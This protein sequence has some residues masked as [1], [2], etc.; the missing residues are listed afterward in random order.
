MESRIT[1]ERALRL[2]EERKQRRREEGGE[3]QRKLRKQQ[4]DEA[5]RRR[6]AEVGR[7][8]HTI[9][10]HLR[11]MALEA[12]RPPAVEPPPLEPPPVEPI[13]EVEEPVFEVGE[14]RLFATDIQI[15]L[16][17]DILAGRAQ[18]ITRNIWLGQLQAREFGIELEEGQFARVEPGV[19]GTPQI[20]LVRPE[21]GLFY[22]PVP[23]QQE[24]VAAPAAVPAPQLDPLL[25]RIYPDVEGLTT[26]E[27]KQIITA[28]PDAFLDDLIKRGRSGDTESLLRELGQSEEEI[29]EIFGEVLPGISDEELL[30]NNYRRTG[31]NFD[32][33]SW[34]YAGR[35]LRPEDE[36]AFGLAPEFFAIGTPGETGWKA[37]WN[38]LRA[39]LSEFAF[40]SRSY[41]LT[42]L[43]EVLF[44]DFKPD[45]S[46][47][48]ELLA[49]H[50]AAQ[51]AQRDEFRK[52]S[53][54]NREKYEEWVA[55]HPELKPPPEWEGEILTLL[56]KDPTLILDP[57]FIGFIAADSA[58]FMA[59]FWAAT[60]TVGV[61]TKNPIAGMAAGV[62]VTT[63]AQSQDLYEDLLQSGATEQQAA[64]LAVPM[65]LL[66]SSVE[67]VGGLAVLRAVGALP[68]MRPFYQLLRRN[69][70][71]ELGKSI[72]KEMAKRGLTS[73]TEIQL[74]EI[75]EEIIQGSIQ[76][77]LVKTFDESRE[78][79]G[80]ITETVL[81]TFIATLPLGILGGGVNVAQTHR[82]MTAEQRQQVQER[83]ATLEEAG[84]TE[85][86]AEMVAFT[87]FAETPEGQVVVD[88]VM[89]QPPEVAPE[90]TPA[91][92]PTTNWK[93]ALKEADETMVELE[94]GQVRPDLTPNT[95]EHQDFIDSE[96]TRIATKYGVPETTLRKQ[97]LWE[98]SPPGV[99]VR[100]PLTEAEIDEL[101][102]G[103]TTRPPATP[104]EAVTLITEP[105][106]GVGEVTPPDMG[107][108]FDAT[109]RALNNIPEGG[110]LDLSDF[111]ELATPFGITRKGNSF[112]FIDADG[113][114]LTT[115]DNAEDAARFAEQLG[116]FT[117]QDIDPTEATR[118]AAY[119]KGE[120]TLPVE[121]PVVEA[122]PPQAVSTVGDEG[123]IIEEGGTPVSPDEAIPSTVVD[124]NPILQDI[125]AR[126]KVRP[127]RKVLTRIGQWRELYKP[128]Q[129]AEVVFNE[130]L[131]AKKKLVREL[132]KLAGKDKSRWSL[133]FREVNEKGSQVGLTF[134][135]KRAV[136]RIKQWADNWADRKNLP[137]DKRIKDYI[138]HLFEEEIT[139]EFTEEAG[140][141]PIAASIISE[142]TIRKITD[143]FLKQRLGAVGFIEDPFAAM[144]AYDT[145]SLRALHYGPIL[146]RLD[147]I[148][149]DPS[150][151]ESVATWLKDYSRRMTG[152]P[153]SFDKAMNVT[154]QEFAEKVKGLPGI[155]ESL[156]K[157]LTVGNPSGRAVYN[158]TSALYTMWLGFKATSAIRNLSQ[159]TLI[160][161]EVGI[162][163]FSKGIG[164][165]FTTEGKAVLA[166]S[167]VL[168][169]RKFAFVEGLDSSFQSR[170][171]KKFAD[172]ALYLFRLADKQNVSDAFLAGYSEGKALLPDA[173]EQVWIDR[174]DE[175]AADT[176][177]LYTKLNSPAWTQD[178]RGRVF[179]MLTSWTTNWMELMTKWIG[180]K[181]SQV[182][183]EQERLTGEKPSQ[184]N[185]STSYKAIGLYMLIVA[186]AYYV[187]E[188]TRIKAF[189]YTGLTSI[190]YL[191]GV[192]GGEFPA[193]Q[194]PGAV[195]AVVAGFLTGDDRRMKQ[196][197]NQL[198]PINMVGILRQLDNVSSGAKDW[199][200][201]L[202]YLEGKDIEITR[203][204]DRW[205]KGWKP[206]EDLSDPLIRA[207]KYPT[208]NKNTAQ[209]RWR[210]ENPLLEVQMFVVGQF[211]TL[212]SEEARQE[213]LRL[214][215]KHKLD[216]ELIDGYEKV[217]GIDTSTELAPFRNRIG[218]LEKLVIGE[219][220]EYY[221]MGRFAEEV[222]KLVNSQGKGKVMR[223]GEPLAVELLNAEDLWK[224]Y[225]DYTED[226]ARKLY[227]QL[228]PDVE[229]QLYLWGKIGSFEN[230][231][232]ATELLR[233][234]EKYNIPPQAINA[235]QQDPEKYDELFTQKFEIEQKNFELSAQYENYSNPEAPNYIED[236][237]ER[238]LAREKFK[239]DNPNW[240]ADMRRIEAIDNDAPPET[241]EK[242]VD[243]GKTIDEFGAG[244]SEAK[245]WLLDNPE[246]HQ[247][248]L[249]NKLLTD[250]GSDWNE[251]VLRLNVELATLD[252]DSE[253]YATVKRKI[254]GHSEGFTAI[255]DF[256]SYYDLPVVG[257]RQER[258]LAEHPAFAAEM[259][260]IKGIEPPDY[261]PPEEYDEL[262]EKE[263]RSPEEEHRIKA[264]D[265]EVPFKHIDDYVN[266][267]SITKPDNW[268]NKRG[269]PL[270]WYEDDWWMVEHPDFYKEVYLDIL[271]N[272]KRDYRKVPPTREIGAKYLTYLRIVDNQAGRGQYRLD[273]TDLDEWGVS[274]GI[275]T[276]TMTEQRLRQ[277]QTPG[278]RLSEEIRER[279]R[280]F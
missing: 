66:I 198:K 93:R 263:T 140:I 47:D 259:K 43:P 185:F 144:E 149:H 220:A 182:Y 18:T 11:Q 154:I 41:F 97:T 162:E 199:L 279:R 111:T 246:V 173:N 190:N 77:A 131:E 74:T 83:E 156:Y 126:E 145:V 48:P 112:E 12:A 175:V 14:E 192:I 221:D 118:L 261:I 277:G 172:R 176:Q 49:R 36:P 241:I 225:F 94:T 28:D 197:L 209:K 222:H 205:Q 23:F 40:S 251:D 231:E 39:S 115:I 68:G 268:V 240:I 90:V 224:P 248:A 174:G 204:K 201:L 6:T 236:K 110:R 104:K 273:N 102:A 134:D 163:H 254:Q 276:T 181:P 213:V 184:V 51:R 228:N 264:Y 208:L 100:R 280:R 80:G 245:A 122:P 89:E 10:Y 157:N 37:V 164:L 64:Q 60:A 98:P 206:Y 252:E 234:M 237:E 141:D 61:V 75:F 169:S 130:E 158:L 278:E 271:G 88:E 193:L 274:A 17:K 52:K 20:R 73:V 3:R 72:I 171:Q 53:V 124:N 67:M 132:R 200:T 243:R 34:R 260:T 70:Q 56:K 191:A 265:K 207:E 262:L 120:V 219:E 146:D 123:V 44:Q 150:T 139:R 247:W 30:Y 125:G 148:M 186:L 82:Q 214:I 59:A 187:K 253:Q 244:S 153:N 8:R 212:S 55:K 270:P 136:A 54:E 216:T 239:E 142:K 65:G 196:G 33:D 103:V 226:G 183:L 87:E 42:T 170:F 189:E 138:P 99:E 227:R 161:G 250:D 113:R 84:F 151:P 255:D 128:I 109:A 9:A 117:S 267:Y 85:E 24:G 269:T 218:N 215:E 15:R 38:N 229:A 57:A 159:H 275:W 32:V 95:K 119:R 4:L 195:A 71:R 21:L 211:T 76:N 101:I 217:F 96:I 232:S 266:Y 135:E 35:P 202:F 272:E 249:D 13:T 116:G 45:P 22:L 86:H 63:P 107:F 2:E 168:R 233:L 143:P 165:R 108:P 180:K 19:N 58:A 194:Y 230:P 92:V 106:V 46:L 31:G 147:S 257:F 155:G 91:E 129:K 238:K 179:S 1:P 105:E 26:E 235:F 137:Q 167:L 188:H 78:V 160:I 127:V 29:N 114:T 152:E 223:D 210:E 16:L 121:V 242:W 27:F 81:R 69:V 256:V 25:Q 79:L 133:I 258:Y 7:T 5:L 62:V 50:N 178:S 203:L 177:Y 166:K